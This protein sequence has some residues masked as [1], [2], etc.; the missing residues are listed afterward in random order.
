MNNR[1]FTLQKAH[2]L[3]QQHISLM[4]TKNSL[5]SQS[6]HKWLVVEITIEKW[7]NGI[8]FL[9]NLS[10]SPLR[11]M[12]QVGITFINVLVP[13]KPLCAFSAT[14]L[15]KI[16]AQHL[17]SGCKWRDSAQVKWH[18]ERKFIRMTVIRIKKIPKLTIPSCHQ[19]RRR[20]LSHRKEGVI[21]GIH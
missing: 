21:L 13:S 1:F 5:Y 2:F 15:L 17:V 12:S 20:V 9:W 16:S 18:I 6:S 10:Q 4:V 11:H 14:L 7:E 8:K 19:A 3:V